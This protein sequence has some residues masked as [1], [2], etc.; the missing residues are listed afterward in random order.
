MKIIVA[1]FTKTGTKSV[2]S[3]LKH[4]GYSVC[5]HLENFWYYRVEWE[6]ILTKGGKR[7]DFKQMYRDFDVVIDSP[8]YYFWKEIHSAF[9]DSK[10]CFYAIIVFERTRVN[11]NSRKVKWCVALPSKAAFALGRLSEQKEKQI[12]IELV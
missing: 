4:L 11:F 9:P 8:S 2:H 6:R 7:E 10:V 5:D 3:A 12:R 1:G